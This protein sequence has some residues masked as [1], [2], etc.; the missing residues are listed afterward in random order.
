VDAA[1]A[2]ISRGDYEAAATIAGRS[3][4]ML[5]GTLRSLYDTGRFARA[6]GSFNPQ[7]IR[8]YLQ[9]CFAAGTP[10]LGEHGSKNI[11]DCLPGDQI[12]SRDESDPAAEPKLRQIE[13]VFV[14][15]G[16]IWHVHVGG[17]VIRTTDEHPFWVENRGWAKACELQPGDMLVGMSG[18][19]RVVEEVFQTG[20]V[21]TVYNFRVA[22]DHTYFVGHAGWGFEVWTH[23]ST[24]VAPMQRHDARWRVQVALQNPGVRVY[25]TAQETLNNPLHAQHITAMVERLAARAPAG[26]YI[27]LNRSW[28]TA[29]GEAA[30][31]SRWS[32]AGRNH[33]D[34]ILVTPGPN[35]QYR[36]SAYEV[37]SPP[38]TAAALEQAMQNAWQSVRG[39]GQ[40]LARRLRFRAVDIGIFPP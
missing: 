29:L 38:Q 3:A 25:G 13:E 30:V 32:L 6:L 9:A 10:I 12:W 24:C 18:A 20:E 17:Q 4:G 15:Q 33:P 19:S 22:E 34:I 39:R 28:R 31:P 14:R 36:V 1:R 16:F 7:Q 35:G 5:P 2:A 11:E 21:E 23:N 27:V 8:G 40:S 37:I 26:S